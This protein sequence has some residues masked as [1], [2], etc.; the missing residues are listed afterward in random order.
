MKR[1]DF[2]TLLGGAAAAWPLG[3][4]AQQG[5]MRRVGVMTGST[6]D[7]QETMSYV[8]AF[9]RT[10]AERG[11]I[12]GRNI[13]FEY[14]TAGDDAD[15]R[16]TYAAELAA[17]APDVIVAGTLPAAQA[18]KDAT[19]AIPIVFASGADPI[20][21][22]LVA[23]LAH[24]GGNVTGFPA[25][26]PTIGGKWVELLKETAPAARRVGVVVDRGNPLRAQY[27]EA[28]AGA[29]Q[30]S[31]LDVTRIELVGDGQVEAAID[32]FAGSRDGTLLVLPGTSN[33]VHRAAIISAA[34]RSRLPAIYPFRRYIASGGL[35][36]YG[37]DNADLYRRAA[38]YV[39]RILRGEKPADLPV[40]L[41]VKFELIINLKTAKA[42]GLTV[43]P[44]MLAR[45]DEVIE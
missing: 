14:R 32:G 7:D 5:P 44:L 31:M 12:E 27:L 35:M 29:A 37:P 15:L 17:M 11:W 22:G 26:E 18:L 19:T 30:R 40:Q 24:P 9:K 21:S 10:L 3:A 16:R 39:D 2:I 4:R 43:P 34:A 38:G 45:A 6:S 20:V 8:A 36:A 28:I 25:F 41:P 42:L 23:S 13:R 1:R 33:Q